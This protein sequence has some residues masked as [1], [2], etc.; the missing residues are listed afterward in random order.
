MEDIVVPFI[1]ITSI[2]IG[3]PWLFLHYMTKWKQ[4][5]KIT[6]EDEQLLDEL[7]LLA[8]R[9]EDR[10]NTV[11]RIVAADNPDFKPS[12]SQPEWRPEGRLGRTDYSLD[13]RN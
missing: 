12:L 9:L 1:A 3:L 6:H 2:F 5:P 7:H 11:E 10:L 13:R 4:A 8:R